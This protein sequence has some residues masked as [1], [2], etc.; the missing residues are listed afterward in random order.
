MKQF[1]VIEVAKIREIITKLGQAREQHAG[2]LAAKKGADAEVDRLASE[3]GQ[4]TAQ[5]DAKEKAMALAGD[6]PEDAGP[7]ELQIGRVARQRRVALAKVSIVEERV[8]ASQQVIEALKKE[9]DAAWLQ[10][11]VAACLEINGRFRQAALS[12]RKIECEYRAW[13]S[14]F[15]SKPGIRGLPAAIVID[16]LVTELY[17][18]LEGVPVWNGHLLDYSMCLGND[19][20]WKPVSGDL[21]D[22]IGALLREVEA[23]KAAALE[24]SL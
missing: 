10:L 6:V 22:A 18:E 16:P 17:V 24:M 2:S 9:L 14:C 21:A 5:R 11:G 23:A 15:A 20:Y 3:I 7:E 19:G 4:A 13:W 8:A 12:L 1:N